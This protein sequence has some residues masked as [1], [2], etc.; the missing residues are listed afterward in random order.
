VA[1][2]WTPR[3][4]WPATLAPPPQAVA[5]YITSRGRVA[6]AELAA[7]S[8]DFID[9]APKEGAAL[10]TRAVAAAALSLDALAG[11]DEGGAA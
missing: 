7:K 5:D 9:L 6:I 8:A 4:P 2:G 1:A 11:D 3:R 10:G